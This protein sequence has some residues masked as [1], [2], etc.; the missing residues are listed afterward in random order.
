MTGS[1]ADF[2][3]LE[4]DFSDDESKPSIGLANIHAV[5][6][7]IEAN[8]DKILRAAEIFKAKKVN[9][10]IFPEF[11][12]SGYFWE[13]EPAC[14]RYMDEAVIENHGDWIEQNLKPLLGDTLRAIVFNNIRRG[15][16]R[17]YFNSTYI[18]SA[19]HDHNI[20]HDMYDKTF[21]PTLEKIYT[22]TAR[23]DRLVVDTPFSGRVGFTTCYDFMFSQLMLEYAMIDKVDTI[24]QLASWRAMARR[25]YPHMNVK[26]DS[27]YGYLWDLMM[28]AT[29]ATNQIWVV[30]CNAVGE[31]GISG[32]RFWGGSG[33]WAPSGLCLVQAS[34][35]NEELLIAHN[36]DIKSHRE[37]ELDDF[38]YALDFASIYRPLKGERAFTRIDI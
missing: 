38:N 22:E 20:P 14:W 31:H 32:A 13:D 19:D 10:A 35:V 18:L 12:L 16:E 30:A 21:L 29:A 33:I 17:K 11:C 36:V 5:V 3:V 28:A 6:P 1:N 26:T 25:D 27:Y 37:F 34:R 4:R 8:K 15:P 24:I 2:F 23:D 9:I 7:G